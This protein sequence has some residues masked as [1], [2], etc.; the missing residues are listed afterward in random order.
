MAARSLTLS[1]WSR[2]WL[3]STMLTMI[4]TVPAT[5]IVIAPMRTWSEDRQAEIDRAVARRVRSA[6]RAAAARVPPV[7]ADPIRGSSGGAGS[8][9]A[10]GGGGGG[11]NRGRVV[12]P[13]SRTPVERSDVVRPSCTVLTA[14]CSRRAGLVADPPHRQH[15]LGLLGV[16]LDL[17]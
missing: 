11:A 7:T 5:A 1:S 8:A 6:I 3:N 4:T 12:S 9:G 16:P 15:D 17:G 13:D 10:S 2:I 14:G